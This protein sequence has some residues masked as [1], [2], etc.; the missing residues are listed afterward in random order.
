MYT[1]SY[2]R[3]RAMHTHTY[4]YVYA[5][6]IHIYLYAIHIHHVSLSL[7]VSLSWLWSTKYRVQNKTIHY[8]P[9]LTEN[10]VTQAHQKR[11]TRKH[12]SS[13][14]FHLCSVA[15]IVLVQ[16]NPSCMS[17]W[18]RHWLWHSSLHDRTRQKHRHFDIPPMSN[19]I[20]SLIIVVT[21]NSTALPDE[22][23]LELPH[24]GWSVYLAHQNR[25]QFFVVMPQ[26]LHDA[27]MQAVWSVCQIYKAHKTIQDTFWFAGGCRPTLSAIGITFI[28]LELYSKTPHIY[29]YIQQMQH[30]TYIQYV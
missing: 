23:G 20:F 21:N 17:L 3:T 16:H 9:Y 6:H 29:K 11:L 5:I 22:T 28:R 7:S 19:M 18:P 14:F 13:R 8:E 24:V 25:L 12:F 10:I 1:I 30:T 4:I 26:H 2:I 15:C 27:S